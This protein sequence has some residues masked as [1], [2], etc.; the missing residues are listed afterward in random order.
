VGGLRKYK[1]DFTKQSFE[2]SYIGYSFNFNQAFKIPGNLSAEFSGYYNS[3][4]FDGSRKIGGFGVIN[5][6]I[7]K[8][9][10]KNGGSFQLSISDILR[11]ER[12][13]VDYG[14]ITEEAF[15][16]KSHVSYYPEPAR[17]PI[18]KL[19]YSRSFGVNKGKAQRS[20]GAND[21]QER[22]RKD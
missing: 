19:S 1:A 12:Y 13:I 3:L 17:A 10:N 21:E 7:K 6:G 9:L 2:K 4:S 22:I 14:S 11:G 20:A 5:A 15:S 8:E 18:V 16:I